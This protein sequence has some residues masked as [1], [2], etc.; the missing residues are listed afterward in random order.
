MTNHVGG[1]FR[2]RTPS[3]IADGVVAWIAVKVPRDWSFR[4]SWTKKRFGDEAMYPS[5]GV[6]AVAQRQL[7]TTIPRGLQVRMQFS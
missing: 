3:K 6:L 1:V 4:W 5:I 7:D 2:W